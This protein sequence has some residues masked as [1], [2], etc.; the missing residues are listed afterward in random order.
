MVQRTKRGLAPGKARETQAKLKAFHDDVRKRCVE[1]PIGSTLYVALDALNS[2]L[3]L[4]ADQLNAGFA[5]NDVSASVG[6][7]R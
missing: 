7:K 2:S 1:I 5:S 4:N 3:N 6:W